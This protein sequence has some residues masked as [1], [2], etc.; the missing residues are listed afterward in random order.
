MHRSKKIMLL[1]L[2]M[3]MILAGMSSMAFA[4]EYSEDDWR[5]SKDGTVLTLYPGQGFVTDNPN[6]VPDWATKAEARDPAFFHLA[7]V[8][9]GTLSLVVDLYLSTGHSTRLTLKGF[10]WWQEKTITVNI[11]RGS[12]YST[13]VVLDAH[14]LE[15]R[16]KFPFGAEIQ[17]V[18]ITEGH[19]CVSARAV[20]ADRDYSGVLLGAVKEGK[21]KVKVTYRLPRYQ[22]PESALIDVT[23][24]S[25]PN[26]EPNPEPKPEEKPEKKVVLKN[27]ISDSVPLFCGTTQCVEEWVAFENC[28]RNDLYADIS[29]TYDDGTSVD[30]VSLRVSVGENGNLLLSSKSKYNEVKSILLDFKFFDLADLTC[31]LL[32]SCVGVTLLPSSEASAWSVDELFNGP[33]ERSFIVENNTKFTLEYTNDLC[34]LMGQPTWDC[35]TVTSIS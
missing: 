2:A 16:V 20:T 28:I 1:L 13:S 9:D 24:E 21:A 31:P 18:K 19:G 32:R 22:C 23:V 34:Q 10:W 7:K 33:I 8:K 11:D 12:E 27:A 14:K 3:V 25:L 17:D 26:P 15:E 35:L 30:F 29:A 6:L 4:S 5:I